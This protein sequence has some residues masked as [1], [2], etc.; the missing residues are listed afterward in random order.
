[1]WKLQK[2]ALKINLPP[3]LLISMTLKPNNKTNHS[4]K[5]KQRKVLSNQ[6]T[7]GSTSKAKVAETADNVMKHW[8]KL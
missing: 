3:L 2:G 7:A 4:L 1:M 5:I 8:N 6:T